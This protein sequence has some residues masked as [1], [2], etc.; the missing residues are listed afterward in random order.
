MSTDSKRSFVVPEEM[1]FLDLVWGQE[2]E[3]EAATDRLIPSLGKK[4]PACL[5]HLGT[6]LSLLDRMASC[7]WACR[8]GDHLVEYLCGRVASNARAALRM[9]RFGFYD[10]ALVLCRS[11]GEVS[12][13]LQLFA[14]DSGTL[15]DWKAATRKERMT[16]FGPMRVRK[17]L[18]DLFEPLIKEER[19]RLLSEQ[20]AHVVPN[21]RP[22]S[23]NV[24]GPPVCWGHITERRCH[25]VSE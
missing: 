11:I 10:E 20:S 22:Q 23:H 14:V 6:V 25:I 1:D 19:Y 9:M 2:D 7:W 18:E 3:C 16:N 12:N 15:A 21:T 17:R 5:N 13:L 24:I 4:A 8:G